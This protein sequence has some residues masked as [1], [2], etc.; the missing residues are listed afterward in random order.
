MKAAV[1]M[2]LYVPENVATSV[3]KLAEKNERSVNDYVV[4][5]LKQHVQDQTQEQPMEIAIK[6]GYKSNAIRTQSCLE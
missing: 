3:K 5:I 4:R 1:R 2:N 6:T